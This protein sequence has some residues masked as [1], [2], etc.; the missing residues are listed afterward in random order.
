[1]KVLLTGGA[2]YI[3]SHVAVCLCEAGYDVVIAD[4]FSNSS[5]DVIDKIEQVTGK[6]IEFYEIDVADSVSLDKLFTES[7]PTSVVHFAGY[8]AVGESVAKPLMYYKNNLITTLA[9]LETMEKHS[10]K[11]II[12]SSSATVYGESEDLPFREDMEHGKATS[13]YG[14]TKQMIERILMDISKNGNINAILLR[15]FNPVGAHKSGQIGE[16]PQGIPN[17]LMPYIYQVATGKLKE[18]SVF[19]ND[20]PTADG[21]GVRDYIHVVD[22]A[23][24]HVAAVKYCKNVSGSEVFNLG[25]GKGYSVLEMIETFSRVNNVSVPYKIVDRRPGDLAE[26]YADV[27]KAKRL[28]NWQTEYDLEDMCKDTYNFKG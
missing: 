13:P 19:G 3:G 23:K 16:K 20:Y 9:L 2:G 28:M 4:D 26:F 27:Q 18:L 25:A 1:M 5:P 14:S 15:Y 7:K 11:D 10:V 12:F 21:T 22:L 24:G 6:K 8:K 17:N